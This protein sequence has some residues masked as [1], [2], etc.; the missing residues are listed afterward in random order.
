MRRIRI[1]IPINVAP[2]GLPTLARRLLLLLLPPPAADTTMRSSKDDGSCDG[3][4]IGN[5]CVEPSEDLLDDMDPLRRKS[6]V[7]AIPM[8][9]KARDVRS[10]AR[11][12]RSTMPDQLC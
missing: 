4:R 7:T 10:Q 6:C 5:P 3:G 11:K 1:P 8:E 12:V 9:A 2:N